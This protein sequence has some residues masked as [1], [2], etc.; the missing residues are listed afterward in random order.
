M[1]T[2]AA[3]RTNER[4]AAEV[5]HAATMLYPTPPALPRRLIRIEVKGRCGSDPLVPLLGDLNQC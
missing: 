3:A 4:V 2:A 1:T 5:A